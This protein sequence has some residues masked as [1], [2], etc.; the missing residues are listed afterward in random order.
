MIELFAVCDNGRRANLCCARFTQTRGA[1]SS[2]RKTVDIVEDVCSNKGLLVV[3]QEVKQNMLN[4][5][6]D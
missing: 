5:L 2:F 4:I 1:A 3:S 6:A